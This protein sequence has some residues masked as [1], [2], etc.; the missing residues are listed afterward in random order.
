MPQF[1]AAT[2]TVDDVVE[3]LDSDGYCIVEGLLS[4]SEAAA[5]KA[6]LRE[7]LDEIPF[8]RNDFEGFSTRR[9]YALF[10]KTRAFDAA[11]IDPLLLGVLD[12]FL[13]HYQ[14]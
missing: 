7:V 10:A 2:V 5:A 13:G 8:G 14:L 1:D 9:V 4:T 11:A 12:R 3:S 6:S